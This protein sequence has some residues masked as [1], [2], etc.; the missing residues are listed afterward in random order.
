ME[1]AEKLPE[2]KSDLRTGNMN[3]IINDVLLALLS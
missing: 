3:R 2:T 1:K